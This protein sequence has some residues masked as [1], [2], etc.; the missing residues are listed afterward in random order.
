MVWCEVGSLRS[1]RTA[2]E[3]LLSNGIDPPEEIWIIPGF[4]NGLYLPRS[5]QEAPQPF[6]SLAFHHRGFTCLLWLI[7]LVFRSFFSLS[8]KCVSKAAGWSLSSDFG[9]IQSLAEDQRCT[10]QQVVVLHSSKYFKNG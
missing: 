1:T 3:S 6:L 9:S 4:Y 2:P 8:I 10:C 5:Q 7:S